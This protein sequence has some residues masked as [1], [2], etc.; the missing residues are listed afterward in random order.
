MMMTTPCRACATPV[1]QPAVSGA[2]AQPTRFM[3]ESLR[4]GWL[5]WHRIINSETHITLFPLTTALDGSS[6]VSAE[7]WLRQRGHVLPP[8]AELLAEALPAPQYQP[9]ER[10]AV[11][12]RIAGKI[13]GSNPCP[14]CGY[15][16]GNKHC[17][18]HDIPAGTGP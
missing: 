11:A 2:G 6:D 5:A 17:P 1:N 18:Q 16:R 7:E 4:E 9:D 13:D 8:L 15:P 12:E 10:L 14:S 3:S